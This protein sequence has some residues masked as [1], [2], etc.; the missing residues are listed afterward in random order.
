MRNFGEDSTV[1][2]TESFEIKLWDNKLI[3]RKSGLWFIQLRTMLKKNFILQVTINIH[4]IYLF[5][6]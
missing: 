1:N 3:N 6:L 2:D 4:I 5:L